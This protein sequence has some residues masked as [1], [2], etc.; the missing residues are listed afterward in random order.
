MAI[1]KGCFFISRTRCYVLNCRW[2]TDIQQQWLSDAIHWYSNNHAW[3]HLDIASWLTW[4]GVWQNHPFSLE[5]IIMRRVCCEL[6]GLFIIIQMSCTACL[7]GKYNFKNEM[8]S[9]T[10]R[11]NGIWA[12]CCLNCLNCS[13]FTSSDQFLLICILRVPWLQGSWGQ[14]GA[15]LGP[16]RPRWAPWWP[17]ELC[18]LGYSQYC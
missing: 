17:H 3:V 11:W 15:H 5:S 4:C 18:Y 6:L 12:Q 10:K 8:S 2:F 9:T 1:N 7:N 16:T 14:H 13:A